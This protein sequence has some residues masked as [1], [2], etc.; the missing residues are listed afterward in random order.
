MGVLVLWLGNRSSK[1][2]SNL[3]SNTNFQRQ[4]QNSSQVMALW[5]KQ[6]KLLLPFC[7]F[8]PKTIQIYQFNSDQSSNF[9][10]PTD[11]F[12]IQLHSD[13]NDPELV[14]TWSAKCS[15]PQD[16][17][18]FRCQQKMRFLSSW[19]ATDFKYRISHKL[20]PLR[21]DNFLE[22]L[23]KLRKVPI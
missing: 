8:F 4:N 14:Q 2:L 15:I 6:V 18:S 21:L 3:Q 16:C 5:Q 13:S 1:K 19:Q 11:C 17:L 7:I 23:T 9:P 20:C 22:R 12:T 10:T